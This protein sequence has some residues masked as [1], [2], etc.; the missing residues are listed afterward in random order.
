MFRVFR[1]FRVC[2]AFIVST[3]A[4]RI[5]RVLRGRR[6]IRVQVFGLS[7]LCPCGVCVCV[8]VLGMGRIVWLV[9][10]REWGNEVPVYSLKGNIWGPNSPIPYEEPGGSWFR[11][12]LFRVWV[13]QGHTCEFFFGG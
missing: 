1:I 8:C 5:I 3:R 4:C 13:K 2:R 7:G 6:A 12:F 10:S 9:L 11:C